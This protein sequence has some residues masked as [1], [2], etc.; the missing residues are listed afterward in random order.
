MRL[1]RHREADR[2]AR[3]RQRGARTGALPRGSP[4]SPRSSTTWRRA[5]R[6]KSPEGGRADVVGSHD[7]PRLQ[8]FPARTPLFNSRGGRDHLASSCLLAGAGIAGN[9]VVGETGAVGMG[10]VGTI[11][12]PG[13]S[14]R[15]GATPSVL[16]TCARPC[17][18][19]RDSP[20]TRQ[21]CTS[22]LSARCS[23]GRG[24][25]SRARVVRCGCGPR[26]ERRDGAGSRSG[27]T[28]IARMRPSR[29]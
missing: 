27:G 23:R 9:R 15:R 10:R 18:P 22:R 5:M 24:E 20:L 11:S 2:H 28:R 26:S 21:V 4:R 3:E 13:G 25:G 6:P 12:P 19:A 14:C 1:R 16:S 7:D 17:S 29:D 8:R